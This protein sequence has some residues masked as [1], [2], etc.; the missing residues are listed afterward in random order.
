MRFYRSILLSIISA[1]LLIL[2]Y[3]LANMWPLTW[4]ALV[5]LFCAFRG[6]KFINVFLLGFLT[7]LVFFYGA[8]YWLNCIAV[9]ATIA[10]VLYLALYFAAFA[11][12]AA[13]ILK[14]NLPIFFKCIF[15]SSWWV[16]LEFIRSN[17]LT[18]FGWS[19]LGYSQAGFLPSIQIADITG[20]WGVSFIVIFFN[21]VVYEFFFSPSLRAPRS[22]AKQSPRLLENRLLNFLFCSFLII[23]VFF[24][25]FY[26]LNLKLVTYDL[27]PLKISLIQGNIPQPLKWDESYKNEIIKKYFDL[28]MAAAQDKPDIIIWPETAY[29]ADLALE[30]V[31]A[32]ELFNLAK[33]VNADLLIG[34]NRYES[35]NIYNSAILIGPDGVIKA[36]YDKL[37]L[38]PFGEFVPK[39][40]KIIF[41]LLPEK[42]NMVGDFSPGEIY[43][44]FESTRA[45][46]HKPQ[47]KFSVLICF[48]DVFPDMARRFVR[49]GA[50]LL[51]NI[52]NDG[53]YGLSSAPFQH[54]Q[55]SVFRAVEN[56]VPVV[57]STNTGYSVF[58]DERGR[59][60]DEIA[61]FTAG[62]KTR[63]IFVGGEHC[64][65][66]YTFYNTYSYAFVII[67]FLLSL[68]GFGIILVHATHKN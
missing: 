25:G 64:S 46:E 44:I 3:P 59:I 32:K 63:D 29:P 54:A 34:A 23:F 31:L 56:R 50:R 2:S 12:F 35:R 52:T 66:L 33:T 15:I 30:P 41:K 4:I 45:Q 49:N 43:T 21:V 53:W 57:R 26:K 60:R 10:L 28:T 65:P 55:A 47:I 11:V 14:K 7:G 37:H 8:I 40:P 1:T 51:V 38:V 17:F 36:H 18:G 62:Y 27:Q 16:C 61:P 39:M 68:L 67:S 6:K 58:I 48:E 13:A 42:I 5:P 22:G 24:Y 20:V 19:L 9:M